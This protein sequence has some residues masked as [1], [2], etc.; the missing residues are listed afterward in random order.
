MGQHDPAKCANCLGTGHLRFSCNLEKKCFKCQK[1]EQIA[2]ECK[3]CD[4]CR[5]YGHETTACR[6]KINRRYAEKETKPQESK[7][8]RKQQG[9][10]HRKYI[11]G[12][13]SQ[14]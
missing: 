14:N 10:E 8:A 1:E 11:G 13:D 4:N 2:G 9:P 5:R 3:K 6:R 7:K 12:P